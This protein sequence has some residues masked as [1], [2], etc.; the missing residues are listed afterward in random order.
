ML[1][2][3]GWSHISWIGNEALGLLA[4]KGCIVRSH[5]S[6]I[7]ERSTGSRR[8]IP[9]QL[10][11]GTKHWA[12]KGVDY[13]ISHQL[14]ME[15]KRWGLKGVDC[16]HWIPK[17]DPTSVGEGNEALGPKWRWKRSAGVW[18]GWIVRS[19]ISWRGELT[20]LYKGARGARDRRGWIVRSQIGLREERNILTRM[21]KPLSSIILRGKSKKDNNAGTKSN[22]TLGHKPK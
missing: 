18:R 2:P 3:E 6:W 10:E 16:E 21:W 4:L 5:I 19:H 11:R 9:H 13:E 22:L 1:D 17:G 7:G 12:P 15:T 14:E 20:I 8:V